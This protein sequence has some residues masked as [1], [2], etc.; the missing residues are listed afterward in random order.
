[1]WVEEVT[2][3]VVPKTLSRVQRK[4]NYL[5]LDSAARQR[6]TQRHLAELEKDNHNEVR[7]E[8]PKQ[9]DAAKRGSTQAVRRILSSRK[10]FGNHF[11]EN[12]TT[13][14]IQ[15]TSGRSH[16]PRRFFCAICGYWGKYKC[17]R[18]GNHTCSISCTATHNE[19]GCLK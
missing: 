13:A 6:Q 9:G 16:Y 4:A 18:C 10:T 7:I 2:A 8:L 3:N 15:A 14:Y 19:A 1:M 12:D 5:T 11:D 17:Q